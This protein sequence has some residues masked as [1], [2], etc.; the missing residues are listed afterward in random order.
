MG[1]LRGPDLD[2]IDFVLI[3]DPLAQIAHKVVIPDVKMGVGIRER[4]FD[5]FSE[6]S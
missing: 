5:C 1:H 2:F 6:A 4:F 3:L